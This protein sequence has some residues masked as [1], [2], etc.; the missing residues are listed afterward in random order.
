M[1]TRTL[2]TFLRMQAQPFLRYCAIGLMNTALDF[3][4]YTTL[5]R[6]W[7]FWETHYLW[8][9]A[10]SFSVIVTW[11]FFWNKYWTFHHQGP[12]HAAQYFKFVLTTLGSIGIAQSIL[13][14]GVHQFGI[15]DLIAKLLAG[16]LVVAWNFLMYRYW[17]FPAHEHA[18]RTGTSLGTQ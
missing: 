10:L 7:K 18:S 13:Y 11:S 17:A 15:S 16:P 1:N 6:G 14:L 8:T 3:T 5:T 2:I 12:W 4:I 9:N